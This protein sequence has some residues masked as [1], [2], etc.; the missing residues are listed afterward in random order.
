MASSRLPKVFAVKA[1]PPAGLARL[2][3]HC[4]VTVNEKKGWPTREDLLQ[5]VRGMDA[6]FVFPFVKIDREVLD[7]AGPQLKIVATHSV[8][9]EHIDLELC[10]ERGI[11]VSYTPDVLTTA[12]AELAVSLVLATARRLD[13]CF[14]AVKEGVW[15]TCW[16]NSL[17]L[18]GK[19]ISGS[20][21][22]IVGLGRIGLAIAKR[23]AAFEVSKIVYTGRTPRPESAAAVGA[24]FV[25][26]DE[27]CKQSD[28]VVASCSVNESNKNL[29]N[30]E[31]FKKMK[32]TSIFVNVA[33]GVIV[34]QEALYEALA[35]GEIGAAG[36]DVT[37][38]EPLPPS[39]PLLTLPNCL[40]VPHIGSL[41]DTTR[42]IMCDLVV[43]N[44]LAGVEGRPIISPAF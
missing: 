6:L 8:G 19:Q 20:V 41:T 15:G 16:E 35:S 11:K 33:R 42:K 17:W 3:Q 24:E 30:R 37:N 43:D 1:I 32:P 10:K 36:L 21:V 14:C 39:D 22:G 31:A 29:F 4:Q 7:V 40:I 23:L 38:P 27:L 44:I 34:D 13:E 18:L 12:T 28:F 26:F 5:G 9:L 25:S 2:R